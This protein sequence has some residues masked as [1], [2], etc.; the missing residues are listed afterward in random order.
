MSFRRG[1]DQ[2]ERNQQSA[3]RRDEFE[4]AKVMLGKAA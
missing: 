3:S 4:P 2:G 1:E